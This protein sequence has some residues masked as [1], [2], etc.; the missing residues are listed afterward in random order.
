VYRIT[1][2]FHKRLSRNE[3]P[4]PYILIQ[5][6]MGFRAYAGKELSRV[7]D[8][9][10][11]IADGSITAD[12]SET[13][14]VSLGVLEKSGRVLSFGSFERALQSRRSD[15]LAAYSSK[16]LQHL[17]IQLNNADRYFS[18]LIATEPFLG[19][20]LWLFSGFESMPQQTHLSR[21]RG[22]IT[23]ITVMP[24]MILQVEER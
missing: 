8:V 16:Q 12:G 4:V 11:L 5:T 17:S 21:L 23:E 20:P 13:A 19:R 3:K 1:L 10:G 22:I 15:V 7:F 24:I 6:H 18:R 9:E 14:G 2:E